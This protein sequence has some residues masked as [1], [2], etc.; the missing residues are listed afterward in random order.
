MYVAP[1]PH[2]DDDPL[3]ALRL[4]SG[5]VLGFVLAVLFQSQMPMLPPALIVGLMAGMRKSFDVK[6]AVGGPVA[7]IAMVLVISMLIDFTRPMPLV[8]IL[9]VWALCVL[10]YYLIMATGNGIGMLVAIVTV[11]M[12]VMRMSS[13]AAMNVLRDGFIEG[14][15]CALAAI[16]IL[17]LVYPPRT[18][19]MAVEVTQPAKE[20]HHVMRAV[21]R[22][23]V[24][25]IM[26]FWLYSVLGSSNLM[27]AVAAVFVLV[28]PT[29]HQQFAEAR[30][31]TISTILAAVISGVILTIFGLVAHFHILLVLIS[32]AGLWLGSQMMSGSYPPMVY[33]FAFSGVISMVAGALTTQEP[34]GAMTL[35]IS[36]TLVGAVGAAFMTAFL[37]KILIPPDAAPASGMTSERIDPESEASLAARDGTAA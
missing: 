14:S 1:R 16:P 28:F 35:R 24:L 26:A 9:L 12:S 34:V 5:A 19:E 25:L 30:E 31:R 33:Q 2:R 11:L 36:L 13:A 15:L 10:S 6:K 20:S 29:A 8:L 4:A 21:I 3:F 37:E 27:L 23:T 17:Y 18:T 7:M 32:L 22:G